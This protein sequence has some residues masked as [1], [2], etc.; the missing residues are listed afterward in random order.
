VVPPGAP[1]LRILVAEDN[2]VNQMLTRKLLERCGHEVVV[3]DDGRSAVTAA[4]AHRFDV[5]LMD[6]Q[7]PEMSGFEAT[8]RIRAHE[9]DAG[10][11]PIIALTAHAMS[12]DR[13]R[14]L[15]AGMDDYLTK[16]ID[17]ARLHELVARWSARARHAA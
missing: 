12:G 9:V 11:V 8:R 1:P 3:V 16:P 2:P 17:K 15:E 5:I 7:M 4:Q 13:E 10:R 6:V 14:C